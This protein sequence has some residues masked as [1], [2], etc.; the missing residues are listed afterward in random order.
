MTLF[1][2]VIMAGGAGTR[3]WPLSRDSMPK[4]FIALLEDDL[5]TFQAT[6]LR[7]KGGSLPAADRDHQP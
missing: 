5:S 2:P 6:L 7:V 3:L 1:V 4:Q